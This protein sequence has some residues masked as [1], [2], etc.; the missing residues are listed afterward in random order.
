MDFKKIIIYGA[1][2][3]GIQI[4]MGLGIFVTPNDMY[5]YAASQDDIKVIHSQL[6]R[7]EEKLDKLIMGY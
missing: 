5:I 1:I 4:A 3:I 6:L 7:I 2:L